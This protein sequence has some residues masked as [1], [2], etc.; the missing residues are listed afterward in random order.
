MNE[1]DHV[2]HVTPCIGPNKASKV[3]DI[4]PAENRYS[5]ILQGNLKATSLLLQCSGP[6]IYQKNEHFGEKNQHYF[7]KNE[8]LLSSI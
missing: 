4:N 1:R 8:H 6:K 3:S 7:Q 5:T 2:S